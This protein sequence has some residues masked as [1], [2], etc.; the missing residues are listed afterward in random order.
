MASAALHT[1]H[2]STGETLLHR[3][4]KQQHIQLVQIFLI[5]WSTCMCI[6]QYAG[7]RMG[8]W[9]PP[10]LQAVSDAIPTVQGN[11]GCH[12]KALEA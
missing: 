5:V 6:L 9:T 7:F 12:G 4:E 10:V 11:S 3:P 2:Q 1:A 8:K